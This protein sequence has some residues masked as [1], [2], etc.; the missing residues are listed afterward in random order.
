MAKELL[1]EIKIKGLDEEINSLKKLQDETKRLRE[2]VKQLETAGS[3]EAERRK[4]ELTETQQQY[5]RLQREVQNRNKAEQES[6]N[7]L[8]KMRAKLAAMNQQ[9]ERTEVGSEKFKQLT[10]QTK[11]LRDEI[12]AA[13]QATGKFQG[14]V[15]NYK[16]AI[17]DAFQQMGL[18]V[19]QLA[20][21]LGQAASGIRAAGTAGQGLTGVVRGLGASLS[22]LGLPLIL[23]A[24]TSIIDIAK[25][26]PGVLDAI[27]RG[28]MPIGA[29]LSRMVGVIED[30]GKGLLAIVKGDFARGFRQIGD[31]VSGWGEAM[32]KA[33]EDGRRLA[34]L[35]TELRGYR[36][37]LA[38]NEGRIT[39][40][41]AEQR[42][43]AMD[44]TRTDKE[45]QAAVEKYI[46]LS[47]TLLELR[48]RELRAELDKLKIQNAQNQTGEEGLLKE[49]QLSSE[50]AAFEAKALNEQRELKLA[51]KRLDEEVAQARMDAIEEERAAR[52]AMAA[53]QQ[54]TIEEG[55]RRALT[56]AEQ[57]WARVRQE[58]PLLRMV[59]EEEIPDIPAIITALGELQQEEIKLAQ[60]TTD[61]IKATYADRFAAL[62]ASLRAGMITEEQYANRKRQLNAMIADDTI[63]SLRGV[64]REGSGIQR[65]LFIFEKIMAVRNAFI[66]LQQGLAKTAGSAPFPA[67]IP[68]MVGFAAQVAGLISAIKSVAAP[69]PP[70]FARGVIGLQGAGS[71]TSDSISA[72]LSK[73]ES[74]MTARATRMFAPVLAQMEMAVGNRPNYQLGNRRFAGGYI[75]APVD[76]LGNMDK[77]IERTIRAIGQIPVVVSERDITETQS[78][79][80]RIKQTGNL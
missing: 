18:N 7:T 67:N 56:A 35:T 22:A 73:G 26:F 74:V 34:E 15:G 50:I 36:L 49:A 58:P 39:R 21:L 44:V 10:A 24:V 75:P 28:L 5:K 9:L 40:D 8:E 1:Y 66:A 20:P 32:R 2:E 29:M 64:A 76:G 14:N 6:V 23:M 60:Q 30:V 62:D 72:K 53:E 47:N 11:K 46:V 63:A 3:A 31:A 70:K 55:L 25:K 65:A 54:A 80:V 45:R 79:V 16:G 51:S 27:N 4:I 38:A 52:R 13:D 69:E 48:R 17:I 43:I 42:E 78:R 37:E 12:N 19:G 68:L 57:V 59:D 61:A 77:V 41:M 71:E 33:Y